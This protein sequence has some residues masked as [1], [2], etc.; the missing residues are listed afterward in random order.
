MKFKLSITKTNE[1]S[2]HQIFTEMS[3]I[4]VSINMELQGYNLTIPSK[5][6][7]SSIKNYYYFLQCLHDFS[8]RLSF[9]PNDLSKI[10]QFI[11]CKLL[12]DTT[13]KYQMNGPLRHK[14]ISAH[15]RVPLSTEKSRFWL[16]YCK[17]IAKKRYLHFVHSLKFLTISINLEN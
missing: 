10:Y 12:R 14:E 9:Y 7:Q 6:W 4:Y 3:E 15:T 1:F 5:I 2:S 13:K 16:A 17:H 8:D 11:M